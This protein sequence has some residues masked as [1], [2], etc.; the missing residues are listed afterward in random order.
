MDGKAS[1]AYARQ[2]PNDQ[3]NSISRFGK[4]FSY[5]AE[6]NIRGIED[7]EKYGVYTA[8]CSDACC[9]WEKKALDEVGGFRWLMAGED[10]V[11]ASMMVKK[12]YK[13]AYVAEAE[14]IHSHNYTLKV[15]FVRHFHT[16]LYRKQWEPV[17]NLGGGGDEKRGAGY[18]KQLLAHIW[19][20]DRK[21]IGLAFLSLVFGFVGYKFGRL[22][23]KRL[24]ISWYQFFSPPWG[25]AD[26]F[27][28][29]VGYKAGLWFEPIDSEKL[30]FKE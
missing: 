21:L 20:T 11:A 17:L 7:V 25:P 26:F 19:K 3:A 12:G 8:F 1:V 13:V 18:A 24:P 16:G 2:L 22:A 23:Y 4:I 27:W 9:A 15:E 14:V 10:A 29:S 5:P 30:I 6:S 28:P